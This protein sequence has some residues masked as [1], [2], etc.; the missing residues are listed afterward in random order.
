M[1]YLIGDI[2]GDITQIMKENLH[3]NGIK[4]SRN[5]VLI[6]LGDFGI[7]FK[8]TEQQRL[9]LD[10]IGQLNYY[11]AFID[12]NHE[13]FD[14]LKSLPIVTKW[15][16]KVHKLNNR[17]F[18][19]LRGN[20][21]KIEGHKYLCFGGAT[22][23]DRAY[24]TLGESYWLEEEPSFV[25]I[26]TLGKSI[27]D[28]SIEHIDFILTHT[29]SNLVLHKMKSIKPID[30]G[31]KTRLVLDKVYDLLKDINHVWFYGHFHTHETIS[32]KYIC[33]T[34]ENVYSISRDKTIGYHEHPFSADTYRF[35]D[36]I[37]L[38]KINQM[39]STISQDNINEIRKIYSEVD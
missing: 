9:A 32:K 2:H 11:V 25:D 24:R 22:S 35:Y 4:I 16:N 6:V 12:G 18:H 31:C 21:Y 33:L 14:Y 17:C 13:N 8:D 29:C 26:N 30:D 39:F 10:Y 7:M 20:I 1:V 5:D 38:M 23:I 28:N 36:Y 27:K 15:G 37:S 34:N 3:N 19:L